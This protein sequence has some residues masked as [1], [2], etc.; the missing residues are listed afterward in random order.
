MVIV[1][2]AWL[3]FT[4]FLFTL[5]NHWFLFFNTTQSPDLLLLFLL[6]YAMDRGKRNG[7]VYGLGIGALLDVVT[8]SYFGWHMVTRAALGT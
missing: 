5:E 6:L 2:L 4:L 3:F 7:A 8:F 1:A